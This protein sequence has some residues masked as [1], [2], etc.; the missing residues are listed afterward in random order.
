MLLYIQC[1]YNKLILLL[2][3]VFL[4]YTFDKFTSYQSCYSNYFLIFPIIILFLVTQW[5]TNRKEINPTVKY[6]NKCDTCSFSLLAA[7]CFRRKPFHSPLSV[8]VN[9]KLTHT[10]GL[11]WTRAALPYIQPDITVCCVLCNCACSIGCPPGW[12]MQRVFTVHVDNNFLMWWQVR[13]GHGRL[14]TGVVEWPL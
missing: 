6:G 5:E 8:A 12:N 11:R 13:Q 4:N 9:V 10:A 14:T 1:L 2:G 7:A 3:A